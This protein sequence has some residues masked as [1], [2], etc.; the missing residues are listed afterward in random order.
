[1]FLH[2]VVALNAYFIFVTTL[3]T[4]VAPSLFFS[5]IFRPCYSGAPFFSLVISTPC[6]F[7]HVC[8]ANSSLA[9]LAS[10]LS[11][12]LFMTA[13]YLQRFSC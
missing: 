4:H 5:G 13:A 1:M 8:A 7:D 11:S 9:F 2:A 6:I 10:A 12:M 3:A